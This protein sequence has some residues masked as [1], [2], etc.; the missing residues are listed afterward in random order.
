MTAP[1]RTI[2]FPLTKGY[3]TIVD[4]CD[5][6]LMQRRWKAVLKNGGI[7][8]ERSAPPYVN[9][10]GQKLR[11]HCVIMERVLERSLQKG[12]IVDHIDGNTLNNRRSNLRIATHAQNI[13][14]GKLRSTNKSGYKGVRFSH[15]KWVSEIKV[16]RQSHY[17]GRFDS[18]EE[19]YDAYCKAAKELHGEF[20]RLK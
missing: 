12:E 4:E 14:N 19:A 3:I 5:A 7:Y 10:R 6:D 13:Q 1:D 18:P 15:G 2:E 16:N 8:A 17:L 20:A 9:R 11:L